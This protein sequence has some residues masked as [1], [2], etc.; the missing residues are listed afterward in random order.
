MALQQLWGKI[1]SF[2]QLT[3]F[4][5]GIMLSIAVFIGFLLI[6]VSYIPPG[7]FLAALLVPFLVE[8]G[9][10]AL[11]DVLDVETDRLNNRMDRPLVSGK[12]TENEARAVAGICLALGILASAMV[13]SWALLITTVF[14][15]FG[16]IYNYRMKDIPLLG[17]M[18]IGTTMGIPFV[19][20]EAAFSGGITAKSAYLFC[21]AF[22]IGFAREIVKSVEDYKGDA[23]ARGSMTL[24]VLVGPKLSMTVAGIVFLA[25]IPFSYFFLIDVFRQIKAI[26][27]IPLM[28]A[29]LLI[30]YSALRCLFCNGECRQEAATVKKATLLAMAIGL[31][32]MLLS[33]I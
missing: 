27:L 5:H 1:V 19:F 17:N 2:A 11:N 20:A 29:Y 3:R 7:L 32:A 9:I 18:F 4:E 28:A 26:A 8:M 16:I 10:F 25:F 23:A 12:V 21:V 30:I 14:A 13:N 22:V 31:L 24:P 6:G 33:Y 15:A